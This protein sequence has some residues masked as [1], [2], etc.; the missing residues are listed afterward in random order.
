MRKFFVLIILLISSLAY[1]Q[2]AWKVC[3]F[4]ISHDGKNTSD[5]VSLAIKSSVSGFLKRDFILINITNTPSILSKDDAYLIALSNGV[6]FAIFGYVSQQ[7]QRMKLV[8]ELIDVA[9]KLVKLSKSYDFFYDVDE[10]FNTIDTIVVDFT[11]GIKKVIPKYEETS[12]VEYR[13]KIKQQQEKLEIPGTFT[14]SVYLSMYLM[15]LGDRESN[16]ITSVYPEISLKYQTIKGSLFGNGWFIGLN[17][18]LSFRAMNSATTNVNNLESSPM[19]AKINL[20]SGINITDLLGIGIDMILFKEIDIINYK[21][22]GNILHISD[23]SIGMAF[24]PMIKFSF[25]NLDIPLFILIMNNDFQ[26]FITL[27][28][29][30]I[31]DLRKDFSNFSMTSIEIRPLYKISKTLN[32]EAKVGI[33]VLTY[34]LTLPGSSQPMEVTFINPSLGISVSRSFSF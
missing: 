14:P 3:F 4:S 13:E 20:Y 24:T 2:D 12:I 11:E 7:E 15:T 6:E 26:S 19:G 16:N 9:N 18:I 23:R 22:Q 30:G 27:G 25:G 17:S 32:I 31:E 21:Q 34:T 33:D 29:K 8:L 5:I 28:T 1:G 10:I